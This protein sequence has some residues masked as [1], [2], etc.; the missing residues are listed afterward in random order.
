MLI[1]L[2]EVDLGAFAPVAREVRPKV[3]ALGASMTLFPLPVREI[4]E[5]VALARSIA[6]SLEARL[7]PETWTC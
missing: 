4:T 2:I 6:S 5:T 7:G 3:V 1:W